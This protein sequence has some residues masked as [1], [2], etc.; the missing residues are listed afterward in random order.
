MVV[1]SRMM[2]WDA[3]MHRGAERGGG[4]AQAVGDDCAPGRDRLAGEV[5]LGAPSERGVQQDGVSHSQVSA[6]RNSPLAMSGEPRTGVSRVLIHSA[7]TNTTSDTENEP[8]R[9]PP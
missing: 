5:L 4:M 7:L 6:S 2:E 3:G 8:S 9:E 1:D